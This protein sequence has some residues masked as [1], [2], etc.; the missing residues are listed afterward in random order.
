M[1]YY[2]ASINLVSL[3]AKA[4]T[5]PDTSISAVNSRRRR[6]ATA[7]QVDRVRNRTFYDYASGHVHLVHRSDAKMG[8]VDENDETLAC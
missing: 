2:L 1:M 8:R 7:L 6:C 5:N 4:M 3:G